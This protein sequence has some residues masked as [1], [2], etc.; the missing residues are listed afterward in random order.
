MCFASLLT[1]KLKVLEPVA[2]VVLLTAFEAA[3]AAATAAVPGRGC[4]GC[5]ADSG[6]TVK[7][8]LGVAR[9]EGDE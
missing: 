9:T 6:V 5:Q 8:E 4:V 2:A 7:E 3:A 1:C